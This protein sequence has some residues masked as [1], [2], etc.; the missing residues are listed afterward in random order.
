MLIVKSPWNSEKVGSVKK[1]NEK[2]LE[3]ILN[4]V[5]Q[6]SRL[7]GVDFPIKDRIKILNNFKEKIKNNISDLANLATSEGGKPITDSLVEIK[8]GAEGVESCIEVLK[9]ESGSVIPMNINEASTGRIA[10]TQKEP[11]G[12]VLAI[13]AFNHPFNLIIHQVIPAIA[14]GCTVIVKPAEDT[15]L[16]CIKILDMLYESG[17]PKERCYFVM[18]EN[19]ELATKLVSDSRIDF[20]SFIGSS[21]VGWFL[22]SKLSSGTRCSLE[23]GGMAP[24]FITKNSDLEM[25]A[26]AISRGSF[27]HAGQ[28]CVSVQRVFV[29]KKVSKDFIDVFIR[30]TKKLKVGDPFLK[31]T[32]V[33]PLIRNSELKRVESWVN[34]S[35]SNKSELVLGGKKISESLYDKTILLNPSKKD[36]VSNFEIFGPVAVINEFN[37][38]EQAILDA[39]SVDVSFQASIFSNK[40]DEILE[41]YEKINAASVFHNDHTAFRVDWMPFAGLKHS[42]HGVGG[43]KYT[44]HDMQVDKMLVLRK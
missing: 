16:S 8:R 25:C 6:I 3:I 20:F 19:L 4:K 21:K 15:P 43:I 22:R 30:E 37:N 5:S 39:N 23:H 24:T 34:E 32:V 1:N 13:S 10:F 26:K 42:G 29:D 40:I 12:V 27:Y 7:K 35:L 14:C 9:N 36:K 2:E 17:L 11:I 33:G 28:V 41:F 18:P 31:D 38:F 44:M